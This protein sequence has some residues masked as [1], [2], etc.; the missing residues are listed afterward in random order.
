MITGKESRRRINHV[1]D[2]MISIPMR[3]AEMH[4]RTKRLFCEKRSSRG[5]NTA[6]NAQMTPDSATGISHRGHAVNL[7]QLA[8]CRTW[9]SEWIFSSKTHRAKKPNR[10]IRQLPD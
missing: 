6:L 3:L 7:L 10:L 9:K 5:V 1:N 8:G 2:Q 4:R